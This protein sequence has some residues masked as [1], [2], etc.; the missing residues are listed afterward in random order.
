MMSRQQQVLLQKKPRMVLCVCGH[1]RELDLLP[2]TSQQVQQD[3]RALLACSSCPACH[4]G[5]RQA[6]A[7]GRRDAF[8]LVPLAGS[9]A[10]QTGL[11]EEVRIHLLEMLYPALAAEALPALLG[12]LNL[13]NDAAF[14]LEHRAVLWSTNKQQMA[15]VLLDLLQSQAQEG[16]TGE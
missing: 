16:S 5:E 7:I 8:G 10:L 9:D 11:A 3:T 13:H 4:R 6:V 15:T 1:S 12:V 14:W 2:T